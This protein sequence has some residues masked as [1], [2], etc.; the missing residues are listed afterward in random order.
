MNQSAYS[1]DS[2]SV[3]DDASLNALQAD[4]SGP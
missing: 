4:R 3:L 2:L 1:F